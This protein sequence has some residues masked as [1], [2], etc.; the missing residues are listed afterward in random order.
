MNKILCMLQ[1]LMKRK[2]DLKFSP[3]NTFLH[4]IC[5]ATGKNCLNNHKSNTLMS[6]HPFLVASQI[7]PTGLSLTQFLYAFSD[8]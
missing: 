1:S 3:I 7:D 8:F 5:E 2:S 4:G 6:N